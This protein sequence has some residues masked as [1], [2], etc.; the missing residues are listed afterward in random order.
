MFNHGRRSFVR[1]L[2]RIIGNSCMAARRRSRALCLV[3]RTVC[4]EALEQLDHHIN[5]LFVLLEVQNEPLSIGEHPQWDGRILQ[6][7]YD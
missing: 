5:G 1:R 6:I 3:L 7:T 4:S 2:A